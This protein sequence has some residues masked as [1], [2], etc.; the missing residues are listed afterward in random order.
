MCVGPDGCRGTGD[1]VLEPDQHSL[2]PAF[3]AVTNRIL[4]RRLVVFIGDAIG[5]AF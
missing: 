2:V 4:R 3:D 1:V 5:N